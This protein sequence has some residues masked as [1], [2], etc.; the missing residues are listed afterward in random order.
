MD[1]KTLCPDEAVVLGE[2]EGIKDKRSCL[3]EDVEAAVK[4]MT[5]YTKESKFQGV[6]KELMA[7]LIMSQPDHPIEH[8]INYLEDHPNPS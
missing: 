6:L 3:K 7:E 2:I 5:N 4:G 1:E 8:L